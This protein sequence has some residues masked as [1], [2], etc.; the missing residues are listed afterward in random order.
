LP[1]EPPFLLQRFISN[2]LF[3]TE[4]KRLILRFFLFD[5]FPQFS[6]SPQAL[7]F[8]YTT[9]CAFHFLPTSTRWIRFP[10]T[11]AGLR[12]FPALLRFKRPMFL[13]FPGL[14]TSFRVTPV[15]NPFLRSLSKDARPRW[16]FLLLPFKPPAPFH[17]ASVLDP[18]ALSLAAVPRWKVF[19]LS[20][21]YLFVDPI[22]P[23]LRTPLSP[24]ANGF[25]PVSNFSFS[26]GMDGLSPII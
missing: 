22:Y 4:P 20:P 8:I 7:L 12:F 2:P 19:P 10:R 13:L 3:L 6:L 14:P 23:H 9:S 18:C 5:P 24:P 17:S 21:P 11:F 16:D 26:V 15:C 1:R 25:P